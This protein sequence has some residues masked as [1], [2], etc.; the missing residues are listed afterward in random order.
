MGVR[1]ARQ[2]AGG[3]D[4]MFDQYPDVAAGLSF[5]GSETSPLYRASVQKKFGLDEAQTQKLQNLQPGANGGTSMKYGYVIFSD[6]PDNDIADEFS[7]S[8]FT[9]WIVPTRLNVKA[10]EYIAVHEFGHAVARHM[11][12]QGSSPEEWSWARDIESVLARGTDVA[13]ERTRALV[14]D[15]LP[16]GGKRTGSEQFKR[17]ISE[18][19]GASPDEAFAESWAEIH[20]SDNPRPYAIGFVNGFSE[21]LGVPVPTS[22]IAKAYKRKFATRE[23]AARFAANARWGGKKNDAVGSDST[24]T[25]FEPWKSQPGIPE[26]EAEWKRRF[27]HMQIGF[28]D[29]APNKANELAAT[30]TELAAQYPEVAARIKYVGDQR[31]MNDINPRGWRPLYALGDSWQTGEWLRFNSDYSAD[32][33]DNVKRDAVATAWSPEGT[34]DLTR[35]LNGR[36][37]SGTRSIMVHEFGHQVDYWLR[38]KALAAAATGAKNHDKLVQSTRIKIK[39]ELNKSNPLVSPVS[40]VTVPRDVKQ[41]MKEALSQYSNKNGRET[42]AEAF[43]EYHLS[44]A[45]RSAARQIISNTFTNV[46]LPVPVMPAVDAITKA[47]QRKYGSRS[48]AGRAAANA[49][50]GGRTAKTGTAETAAVQIEPWVDQGSI[51]DINKAFNER[52]GERTILDLTGADINAANGIADGLNELLTLYPDTELHFVGTEDVFKNAFSGRGV[53][54]PPSLSKERKK[55]LIDLGQQF[56]I[57]AMGAGVAGSYITT[58]Q[59]IRINADLIAPNEALRFALSSVQS[60]DNNFYAKTGLMGKGKISTVVKETAK[61]TLVH[62]FGHAIDFTGSHPFGMV[63]VSK[64]T[65]SSADP[66][67]RAMAGMA[68]TP[69]SRKK[70]VANYIGEY[71]STNSPELFAE[72]FT[73]YH[74]NPKPRKLSVDQAQH[75]MKQANKTLAQPSMSNGIEKAYQRK[76]GSR[77]EA[78]RAAANARWGNRAKTE[79]TGSDSGS[80]DRYVPSEKL[81]DAIDKSAAID[82][83]P[84][85]FEE[86]AKT[87]EGKKIIAEYA[88]KVFANEDF[89][90]QVG[91]YAA[92][93]LYR[94]ARRQAEERVFY[95][96]LEEWPGHIASN[97]Q[98]L[99]EILATQPVTINLTSDDLEKVFQDGRFKSQFETGDSEGAY[100]PEKRNET[101]AI[102]F[103]YSTRTTSPEKRPIYGSIP[104]F[105]AAALA[106]PGETG[107]WL[108]GDTR[109]VLKDSVRSRTTFTAGDSLGMGWNPSSVENPRLNGASLTTKKPYVGYIEAQIHGGVNVSDIKELV[110]KDPRKAY[111][112][113]PDPKDSVAAKIGKQFGIPVRVLDLDGTVTTLG[114]SA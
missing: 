1:F 52:W 85:P 3:L 81:L 66:V 31:G 4:T 95:G 82:D 13:V 86:F 41:A 23:E 35:T 54:L 89:P 93:I 12:K 20:L 107:T 99:K 90:E 25:Q 101:E 44:D 91:K 88:E 70:F 76:Y 106:R 84:V 104:E 11:G 112:N 9:G 6:K 15:D 30:F 16:D 87:P 68:M 114:E 2:A 78:A 38:E 72:V 21:G 33:M 48:E 37:I 79:D 22:K 98:K 8:Q 56:G 7:M 102:V 51:K 65:E 5:V 55:E 73:E 105:G 111:P 108:Y 59:G 50:W 17:A 58:V 40:R 53:S 75:V 28:R 10:G 45:P 49:R 36:R 61:R 103:G 62:E 47:Y 64:R 39:N 67:G 83:P 113:S 110:V 100:N 42:F 19:A 69:E 34:W 71:A 43:V 96:E 14:T 32:A 97:Q 80:V 18:Y 94:N 74:L 29:T 57:P 109:V 26:I 46:G 27:P 63:P 77:T 24:S 60:E 92:S